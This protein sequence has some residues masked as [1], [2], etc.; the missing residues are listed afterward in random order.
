MHVFHTLFITQIQVKWDPGQALIGTFEKVI[1][2]HRDFLPTPR[3]G[4][5]V[6]SP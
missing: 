4:S 5:H 2:I 6:K 1:I 3:R